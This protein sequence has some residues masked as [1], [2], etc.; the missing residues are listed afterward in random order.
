MNKVNK[1]SNLNEGYIQIKGACEHNLKHIDVNIPRGKF[2]V[3]SGLSGS[4]K[5]SLAFDT[6]YAEGQRR[7]VV[8]LSA[9]ARQFMGKIQKPKIDSIDGIPPAI[10][11]TQKV[12]NSNPRSTVGTTTEIYDYLK[13]LYARIG[14]TI[15][16]ISG[17]VVKQDTVSDVIDF[18]R[19]FQTGIKALLLAPLHVTEGRNYK[20][21]LEILQKQGFIR[22]EFDEHIKKIDEI[23]SSNNFKTPKTAYIVIDRIIFK[24]DEDTLSRIADSVQT[25]F[26]EGRGVCGIRVLSD[27]NPVFKEFS[28]MF[29]A[30]GIDF[31]RPT[32]HSFDFNSPAGACPECGGFGKTLGID[33]DLVIPNKSLSIYQGAIAPWR[34]EKMSRYKDDFINVA[35]KFNFPIH[36]PYFQLSQKQKEE[37]WEGNRYF[38]GLYTF[39]DIIKSKSR[40]IQFR[41]ML[42]RY[43]GRTICHACKGNRLKKE[44]N[45][46]KIAGKSINDLINIPMSELKIFFDNLEL[47]QHKSEVGKRIL[48][49]IKSR[50][51]S[52][53]DMGLGYLC[54]NRPSASLS[55]GEAQRINIAG[56]LGSSLTGSLYVLDE[57]SIGLHPRDTHKLIKVLKEL[58]DLGNT[59][60]LTEHDEDIIKSADLVIDIGQF[61]GNK[62]GNL[63]YEGAFDAEANMMLP[64]S[65]ISFT[66]KYI[67]GEMS[68]ALPKKR[69]HPTGF[70]SLKGVVKHNL[71]NINIDIPLGVL[72]AVSGVSGSG[73]STLIKDVFY[74]ALKSYIDGVEMKQGCF[75]ELRGDLHKLQQV[76]FVSQNPIGKSSRS[77]PATYL[78]LYD[79]IRKL[80][81]NQQ[82]AKINNLKAGDFSFNIEGG[83]CETCKGEGEITVEM[84]FM[85]DV[86]LLCEECKG[87]RFKQEV[88]DVLFRGKNIY[89][90]LNMTVEDAQEFFSQS[91][92]STDIAELIQPLVDVGLSYIKLGQASNTLSGGESQRIKLA[93]FL[94][95]GNKKHNTLFIFDEP[96]TGLHLHDINQLL[97]AF[98]KLITNGNSIL[99]IEHNTE[100]IKTADYIIDLGKEGGDAGGE[101]VF[102]GTPEELVKCPNSYT[103]IFLKDKVV[104]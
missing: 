68:I 42:S 10:A 84:Q 43:S 22:V 57:P 46:V 48:H 66:A 69:R 44:T 8:S 96:T 101:V 14:D 71:K 79:N 15:S 41:V 97:S 16:P 1:K 70:I 55:G 81:A 53:C 19:T 72:T 83:R 6:L 56:S 76:E 24:D 54:L 7:Y 102:A 23:L 82:S 103:G 49:E 5:S 20:E 58:R 60:V 4:G 9:Y 29:S 26:Y 25:A 77:N 50:L 11:I 51:Q 3:I 104:E 27:E 12:N 64:K 62:G 92:E 86:K 17:D 89:D 61:A 21:E 36:R 99:V 33:Q 18:L 13:L 85:A 34:G 94:S 98:N 32:V 78:K 30:D 40:K 37:L 38:A 74:P 91:P 52:I 28:N 95:K 47:N 67:N 80:F 88:L 90:I 65:N 35:H 59:V 63:I 45:Y 31:T 87:Q 93:S 75:N 39:F 2:V 73:K 100:L